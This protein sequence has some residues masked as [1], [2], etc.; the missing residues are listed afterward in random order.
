MRLAGGLGARSRGDA[1]HGNRLMKAKEDQMG[2]TDVR[3]VAA[4]YDIHG[5]LPALEAALSAVD[6]ARADGIVVGGD[7]VLGPMPR[8]TLDRLLALGPRARFIRGNCDRLVVDAFDGRPLTRWPPVIREPIAWTTQQLDR[9][10][11]DF[12]ASLPDTLVVN[13][14]GLGGV[15]FCH[16]TPRSDEE[17]FT[18]STPAEHLR[19]MLDGVT[20]SLVV[21]GHTHMQFDR[22]V[23]G[24]RLIN[25]GSVGMPY[26]RPG[27]YWLLLGP[28]VRLMRTEYD[29]ERTAELVRKTSY[30]HAAEF[31][32]R[33]VLSPDTEQEALSLFEQMPP[34][35]QTPQR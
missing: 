16:A 27:A 15:L 21:C 32:S 25:A 31:A 23:D 28:D 29:L 13:V 6:S 8:E 11:R 9:H 7:V 33:H 2:T 18:A 20:Q 1:L 22:S 12:L 35:T 19:P 4:L 3:Q 5:N 10:H 34:R 24:V 30:P 14:Q 26:G 17:I